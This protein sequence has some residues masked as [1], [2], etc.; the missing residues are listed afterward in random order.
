[1][2]TIKELKDFVGDKGRLF[3][4]SFIKSDNTI[5]NMVVRFGVR[6]YT[7]GRGLSYNPFKK[8]N[9]IVFSMQ[10]DAFRTFKM[11]RLL[12]VKA[13]GKKVVIK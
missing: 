10:D 1:M 7:S 6:K 3:S 4:V 5:R 11:D 13:N 8:N 12:S 9:V 2:K